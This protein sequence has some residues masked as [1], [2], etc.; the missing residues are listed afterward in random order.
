MWG[1]VQCWFMSLELYDFTFLYPRML[2]RLS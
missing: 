2:V 1:V